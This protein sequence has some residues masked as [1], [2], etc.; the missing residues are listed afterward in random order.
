M[1]QD[2]FKDVIGTFNIGDR[3]SI[4]TRELANTNKNPLPVII[5]DIVE[6]DPS[7]IT[8]SEKTFTGFSNFQ[9]RYHFDN[10]VE[11]KKVSTDNNRISDFDFLQRC[12]IGDQLSI[13][14]RQ[15]II[16]DIPRKVPSVLP[17]IV[18]KLA[19]KTNEYI[20]LAISEI[21]KDGKKILESRMQIA[22]ND[23]IY[24]ERIY[25]SNSTESYIINIDDQPSSRILIPNEYY[26][27]ENPDGSI[28]LCYK[29][30]T[31]VSVVT[32]FGKLV[33]Y[34]GFGYNSEKCITLVRKNNNNDID[35]EELL[36][37][38]L[39]IIIHIEI[40]GDN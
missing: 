14:T 31:K 1:Y 5:G 22:L 20:S 12:N 23:I 11:I 34:F 39:D 10:I 40:I 36:E 18:G 24:I 9:S 33:G 30:N 16:D 21:S 7:F 2:K 37:I 17:P 15:M 32:V 35:E 29:P 28:C 25:D 4:I 26:L 38:P 8:L 19:E 6:I 13:T 3:V 27:Y